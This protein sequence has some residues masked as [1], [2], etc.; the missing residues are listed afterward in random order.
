MYANKCKDQKPFRK[1][2]RCRD[3]VNRQRDKL[4]Y[5]RCMLWHM[6]Y[7]KCNAG[8]SLNHTKAAGC[9][10]WKLKLLVSNIFQSCYSFRKFS[11]NCPTRSLKCYT[12]KSGLF[13]IK[14]D[15]YECHSDLA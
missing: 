10:N 2:E 5:N 1:T 12:V 6:K 7:K 3:N 14:L 8:Y 15:S 9:V 11:S 4:F 13:D